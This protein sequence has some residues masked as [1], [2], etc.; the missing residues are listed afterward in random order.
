MRHHR[1]QG[2][3]YSAIALVCL[4]G[5]VAGFY[6]GAKSLAILAFMGMFGTCVCA[7]VDRT[8]YVHH[9]RRARWHEAAMSAEEDRLAAGK[10]G[11]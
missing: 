10:E 4:I 11:Q 7:A 2:A 1:T 8:E 3:W 5:T 6:L 9:R